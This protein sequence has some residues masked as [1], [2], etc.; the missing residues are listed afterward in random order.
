VFAPDLVNVRELLPELQAFL[1]NSQTFL[2]SGTAT[3]NSYTI[4]VLL[5]ADCI[6]AC[7]SVALASWQRR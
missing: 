1:A 4:T 3:E 5:S 7:F 6:G 2:R